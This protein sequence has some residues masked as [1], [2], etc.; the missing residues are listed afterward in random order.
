ML[1][2]FVAGTT[3]FQGTDV[4]KMEHRRAALK[5]RMEPRLKKEFEPRLEKKF[6]GGRK[7]KYGGNFAFFY[8]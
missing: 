2:V 3:K 1:V 8:Y 7:K 4:L 6:G 5:I